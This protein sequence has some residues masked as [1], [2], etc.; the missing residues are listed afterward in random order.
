MLDSLNNEITDHGNIIAGKKLTQ[1]EKYCISMQFPFSAQVIW[2]LGDKQKGNKNQK[3][4]LV[5]HNS[6]KLFLGI[7]AVFK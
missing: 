7:S 2:D 3:S 1:N 5:Y 4:F 6:N